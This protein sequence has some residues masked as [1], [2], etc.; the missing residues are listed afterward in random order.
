MQCAARLAL[1]RELV[2]PAQA[3]KYWDIKPAVQ[4]NLVAISA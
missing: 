1:E 4:F 3:A 2:T